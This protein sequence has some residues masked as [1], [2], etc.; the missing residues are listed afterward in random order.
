MLFR[1]TRIKVS[2]KIPPIITNN[3]KSLL[4]FFIIN[5][6]GSS[7]FRTDHLLCARQM[8]Y[9]MSYGPLLH[10]YNLLWKQRISGYFCLFNLLIFLTFMETARRAEITIKNPPIINK[11]LLL[12]FGFFPCVS[13]SSLRNLVNEFS[14]SFILF[15]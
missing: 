9:Q 13:V 3:K 1:T 2:V 14:T 6:G 5:I 4:L 10:I 15:W 8:L 12:S 11:F 7:R